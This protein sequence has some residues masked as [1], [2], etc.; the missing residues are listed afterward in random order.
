MAGEVKSLFIENVKHKYE[1]KGCKEMVHSKQIREHDEVCSY[2]LVLC[3]STLHLCGKQLAASSSAGPATP[4]SGN[5][6]FNSSVE[7][8]SASTRG[9][10]LGSVLPDWPAGPVVPG[11]VATQRTE[12]QGDETRLEADALAERWRAGTPCVTRWEEGEGGDGCWYCAVADSVSRATRWS[13]SPT[14]ATALPVHC[15]C[16]GRL[17]PPSARTDC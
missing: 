9:S 7:E 3:P 4:R 13:P 14:T 6:T 16:S 12:G 2:R 5:V 15:T 10:S 8:I 1:Y 11:E 17:T